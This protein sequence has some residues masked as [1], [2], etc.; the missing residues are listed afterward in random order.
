MTR[1]H[2]KNRKMRNYIFLAALAISSVLA[3]QTDIEMALETVD[4]NE[5]EGPYLFFG[6]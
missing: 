4:K 1:I 3:A 2:Q 6:R 5:I